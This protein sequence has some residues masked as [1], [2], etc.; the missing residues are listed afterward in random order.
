ML[1]ENNKVQDLFF[2]TPFSNKIQVN[3]RFVFSF[4][5]YHPFKKRNEQPMLIKNN[6]VQDLFFETP[7]SNKS[8]VNKSV[9]FSFKRLP[10][11]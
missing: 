11:L 9:V 4:K 5:D 6:K 1:I 3:K 7:F 2:E 10:S 8:Q